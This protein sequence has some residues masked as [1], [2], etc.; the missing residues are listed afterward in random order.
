ML[1]HKYTDASVQKGEIPGVSNSFEHT[2]AM[3]QLLHEAIINHKDLT[4]VWLDQA[5]AYGSIPLPTT[6][7]GYASVL[8]PRPFK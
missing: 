2:R 4:V 8:H 5:H 6:T 3:T 1:R 7:S